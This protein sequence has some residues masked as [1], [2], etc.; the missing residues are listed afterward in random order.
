M[1]EKIWAKSKG[2]CLMEDQKKS[3]QR[4]FKFLGL[5]LFIMTL[6]LSCVSVRLWDS[7]CVAFENKNMKNDE[8]RSFVLSSTESKKF[9]YYEIRYVWYDPETKRHYLEINQNFYGEFQPRMKLIA[10]YVYCSQR[11]R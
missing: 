4:G 1:S 2:R 8:F 7:P 6:A 11:K 10:A 3:V 5:F 9:D